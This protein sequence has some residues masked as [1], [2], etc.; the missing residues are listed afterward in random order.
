[1]TCLLLDGANLALEVRTDETG[2]KIVLF[3]FFGLFWQSILLFVGFTFIN[4]NIQPNSYYK[5]LNLFKIIEN[6]VIISRTRTVL[7]LLTYNFV[8]YSDHEGV[9]WPDCTIRYN[10]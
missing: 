5:S 1:M 4:K 10:T 2:L 9:I 6:N 3:V 8:E 7:H